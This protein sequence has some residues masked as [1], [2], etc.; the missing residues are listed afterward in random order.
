MV[1]VIPSA[2]VVVLLSSSSSFFFLFSSS[3]SVCLTI[4]SSVLSSS[5][6]CSFL[7]SS[8]A[9][10]AFCVMVAVKA[11]SSCSRRTSANFVSELF[12]VWWNCSFMFVSSG[13]S[14]LQSTQIRSPLGIVPVFLHSCR[15]AKWL[16]DLARLLFVLLYSCRKP[17]NDSSWFL[18]CG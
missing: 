8:L 15:K 7:S 10:L 5:S 6:S 18:W 16:F 3:L 14:A 17:S 11:V 2:C 13:M 9:A 4:F 12:F 1:L